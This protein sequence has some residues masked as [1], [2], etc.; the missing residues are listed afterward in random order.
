MLSH[1]KVSAWSVRCSSELFPDRVA[2]VAAVKEGTLQLLEVLIAIF[3]VDADPV[4]PEC[5]AVWDG[6]LHLS[7][8]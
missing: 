1:Q 3:S 4:N 5:L 8:M 7:G 2:L 6:F